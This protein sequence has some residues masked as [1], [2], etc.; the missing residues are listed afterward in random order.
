MGPSLRWVSIVVRARLAPAT[1]RLAARP[2]RGRSHAVR[3]QGGRR[4]ERGFT[5]IEVLVSTTISFAVV[6]ALLAAYTAAAQSGRSSQAVIQMAE[7]ATLA[8][9]MLRTQVAM[10]G[11]GT[12]IDASGPRFKTR[13]T[14]SPLFG[15]NGAGFADPSAAMDS[16]RCAMSS[17]PAAPDALAVGYEVV[18]NEADQRRYANSV[19][20]ADA[21]PYDC[22]GNTLPAT[23]K[24]YQADSHFYLATP[25]GATHPALYCAQGGA[26]VSGQPIAENVVD[27]QVRYL[28]AASP[29]EHQATHFSEAPA[30]LPGAASPWSNV[31]AVRLCLEVVSASKFPDAVRD[32]FLDCAD[33]PR[34]ASDGYLHRAFTTTVF[35]QNKS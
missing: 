24:A 1:Q 4:S 35:L 32:K 18:V 34:E 2:V 22:I 9:N 27:F 8:L 19:V 28:M 11:Y 26:L 3:R 31:S 6:G 15:C 29:H 13:Y 23:A 12:P 25:P 17:A 7:D 20:S 33:T 5:L 16:L 14:A 21:E 10:A 30:P